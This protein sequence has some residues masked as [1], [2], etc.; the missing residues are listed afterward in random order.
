LIAVPPRFSDRI[1]KLRAPLEREDREGNW[2]WLRWLADTALEDLHGTVFGVYNFVIG[3][4]IL[5]ASTLAGALWSTY[6]SAFT[7]FAG[8]AFAALALVGLLAGGHALAKP[9]REVEL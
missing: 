5:L 2:P 6:G 1:T 4:A 9:P 8:A 7:F 3:A